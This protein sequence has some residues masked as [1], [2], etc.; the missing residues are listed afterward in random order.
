[1]YGNLNV[2]IYNLSANFLFPT[3]ALITH[4]L[5]GG[6]AE[7]MSISMVGMFT[8]RKSSCLVS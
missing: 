6:P 5:L 7:I 2:T 8:I 1:M 3:E 4:L